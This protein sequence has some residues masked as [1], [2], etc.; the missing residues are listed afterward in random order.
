EVVAELERQLRKLERTFDRGPRDFSV[1]LARVSIT[2]REERAVDWDRKKESRS[3]DELLAIDVPAPAAW[4][5]RR[6][7]AGLRRRHA[8]HAEKGR[9]RNRRVRRTGPG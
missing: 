9:E 1:A 2:R 5:S 8:E 6:M 4:R 3:G 7:S